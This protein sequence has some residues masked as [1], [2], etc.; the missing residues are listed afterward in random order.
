VALSWK[1]I[2]LIFSS[3]FLSTL[4]DRAM[5]PPL[6]TIQQDIQVNF[7]YAVHFTQDLFAADNPLFKDIVAPDSTG[8]PR[9]VLVVLDRGVHRHHPQLLPKIEAYCRR[10]HESLTLVGAPL[11]FQGGENLKNDSLY[12][13]ILQQAIH[14]A[15]LCRHS[16]VVA[17]GGGALIDLAGFAAATAHRGIRLIRVPTTVMAQADAAI[18]VKNGI[19]AFGKKNFIGT[20]APPVAVLNDADFLSTLSQRD[21]IGGVAEAVKVALVKDSA[22]FTFLEEHAEALAERDLALMQQVIYR[23]AVLHL[24]HIAKGGDPFEFGS[25][26][27]LD[28]GHWAAHK[29]EHLS[30]FELG[31]G[32]AVA[33]GIALDSTYA[34]LTGLLPQS[35]WQ[36]ILATLRTLGFTLSTPW[37]DIRH[38]LLD[39]LNE[40]REHLGGRL[41]IML[42]WDIGQGLEVH[43]VDP[44]LLR[45]SLTVLAESSLASPGHG[46]RSAVQGAPRPG[47]RSLATTKLRQ[48]R[49]LSSDKRGASG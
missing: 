2:I 31:H 28:F 43:D 14:A 19:N 3:K 46:A 38:G 4:E 13:T 29:L 36:R 17:L 24:D 37:L 32:Q 30:G 8:S 6:T 11:L 9:K 18:G 44:E 45:Q 47:L 49:L 10:H 7:R 12:V 42:L 20:F 5:P 1:L 48:L 34:Y 15:G 26:R 25:S 39:G 33:I 21:W 16:Y 22:F 41:T 27:P 40:F 23:C 35:Q